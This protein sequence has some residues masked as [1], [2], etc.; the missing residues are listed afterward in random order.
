MAAPRPLSPEP[1]NTSR[2][3]AGI[4]R[5]AGW[6]AYSG[7]WDKRFASCSRAML[8]WLEGSPSDKVFFARW[9]CGSLMRSRPSAGWKLQCLGSVR[10]LSPWLIALRYFGAKCL[11]ITRAST[12]QSRSVSWAPAPREIKAPFN[13][14]A[15]S[16]HAASSMALLDDYAARNQWVLA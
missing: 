3:A 1:R 6:L 15:A 8:T 4:A 13:S 7:C 9:C 5:V 16:S 14:I 11:A 2:A 12:T 10:H